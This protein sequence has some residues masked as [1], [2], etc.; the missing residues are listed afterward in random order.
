MASSGDI[1][2]NEAM[3]RYCFDVLTAHFDGRDVNGVPKVDPSDSVSVGG[4]F[5]TLNIFN[6]SGHKQLRGCIGRLSELRLNEM[7]NYVLMSAFKDSRFD[8]L[9]A[10]ELPKLEVAISLLIKY[11]PADN[12][13]DWEVTAMMS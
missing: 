5:V 13:L 3:C 7:S 10:D 4:M 2:S 9:T 6:S 8:P 1:E 12:Y 11:E